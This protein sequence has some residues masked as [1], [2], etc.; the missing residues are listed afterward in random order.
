LER[1]LA[2]GRRRFDETWHRLR[3]WTGGQA[4]EEM[5]SW[6]VIA[7]AGYIKIDPSHPHGGP[8]KGAD[9]LC[10][11]DGEKWVLAVYFARGEKPYPAIKNKL[12]KD[13]KGAKSRGAVGIVF[14][15]NQELRL[16]EREKLEQ[17]DP[18]LK[19]DVFHLL[20]VTEFLDEPK[21]ARLLEDYLDIVTGPAPVLIKAEIAGVARGFLDE[22]AVL[23]FFV[24]YH[25]QQVR[26]ESDR[27]W[28][29]VREEEAEKERAKRE[30]A[31]ERARRATK[32][33]ATLA[34]MTSAFM[35]D[36]SDI[37][38]NYGLGLGMMPTADAN[39]LKQFGV[40][41]PEPPK[42]RT[43][44][45]IVAESARYRA[46][47]EARWPECRK[48]LAGV[49]WPGLAFRIE[50]VE[51]SFLRNVQVI[52]TFQG[53]SGVDY[54]DGDTFEWNKLEN[55]EW[56]LSYG[57]SPWMASA[58]APPVPFIRPKDYPVEWEH[59]ENGDLVVT[60]T[61][62]EL[63]PRQVWRS[64]DD[65][66]VLVL[67]DRDIHQVMVSYTATAVEYHDLF[68]GEP[69][70]VPVETAPMFDVFKAAFEASKDVS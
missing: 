54:E 22:G 15:T 30:R 65:D 6:Q 37:M 55:P 24:D 3:D 29:T 2:T 70:T 7:A 53:A 52:L 25:Q 34:D 67:R 41:E 18:D 1:A 62:P 4:E 49:A 60:I 10:E 16:A 59:N 20:R 28:A 50:N 68:E 35:P 57:G 5:L 39:I 61:L 13:M 9:A 56:E 12:V 64:A 36:V 51:K 63:R 27:A 40:E 17:L 11:K 48:Y 38:P 42:P 43:D 47:L 31:A 32:P 8:D 58:I 14:V 26:E 45:E 44:E 66:V 19:V 33:G 46:E 21:N 23:D 69:I